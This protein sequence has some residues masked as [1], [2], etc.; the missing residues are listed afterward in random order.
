MAKT[1]DLIFLEVFNKYLIMITNKRFK[2]KYYNNFCSKNKPPLSSFDYLFRIY[3]YSQMP[4][5][6]LAFFH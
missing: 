1:S 6:V 3:K 5:A 4:E 2:Y